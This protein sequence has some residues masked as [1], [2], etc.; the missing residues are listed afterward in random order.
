MSGEKKLKINYSLY[1][2]LIV[3]AFFTYRSSI[4]VE[5]NLANLWRGTVYMR[6]F[7]SRM[8][9][10]DFSIL[11]SVIDETIITIHLAW[12][13]TILAAILSLPIAFLAASNLSGSRALRSLIL[14]LLSADRAIDSI[15]LALFFVSAVGLG[16]FAGT[17]ALAIH[18]VGMLA[19][20]FADAIE[21]IDRGPIE[22]LESAGAGKLATIRWAV[23]PQV[24][25]LF[26][27]YFLFRFELNVRAAIVLGFVG[28][29]GIGFMLW[30]HTRLFQYEKVTTILLVILVLVMSLDFLSSKL[31]RSMI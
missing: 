10:P 27:S 22:A 4:A 31:R 14:F 17:L 19:K 24:S 12:I 20:L 9:P 16:P 30:Q 6:D 21:G 26:V 11:K 29:G 13:A 2:I 23:W 28:A 1:L 7:L 5:I 3:L 15:I 8:W 25:P 18:S